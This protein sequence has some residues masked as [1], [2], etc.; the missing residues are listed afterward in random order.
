[1]EWF[2]CNKCMVTRGSKFAV[3]SCGHV[4]CEACIVTPEQC[5]ACGSSCRY[6][7]ITDQMKPQE[8]V[9]FKDPVMLVQS[10]LEHISK[11]ATFQ[12]AQMRRATEY[13]KHKSVTLEKNLQEVTDKSYRQ[14]A[15]LKRENADL[16]KLNMDLKSEMAELKKPLSQR[17]VSPGQF[18]KNGVQRISLPVGVTSPVTPPFG[19][20]RLSHLP[21]WPRDRDLASRTTP[22]ST[23]SFSSHSSHSH[24][25]PI[26]SPATRTSNIFQFP[27]MN[28]LSIHTPRH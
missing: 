6:I 12:Q 23:T 1:M 21:V 27:L 2:H 25:T 15:E 8:I 17:R 9:L 20:I 7:A 24:R 14:I 5:G 3:S 11:I 19:T 28:S 4:I 10:R 22:G 26:N 13:F 16:K 18:Q